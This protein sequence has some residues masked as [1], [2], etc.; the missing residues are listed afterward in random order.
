MNFVSRCLRSSVLVALAIATG[1]AQTQP[2]SPG[3]SMPQ[4]QTSPAQTPPT[5]PAETPA[6]PQAQ[7]TQPEQT[8]QSTPPAAQQSSGT[9]IAI[10]IDD[11]E[12]A[13]KQFNDLRDGVSAFVKAFGEEDELSLIGVGDKP[14]VLQDLTYDPA[15][16][17]E[18]VRKVRPQG[19]PNLASAVQ[20]AKEHLQ[21]EAEN[22][23]TAIVL[24]VGSE[25][26]I[27]VLPGAAD[28]K[29]TEAVKIPIQVI[30]SPGADWQMQEKLQELT[31]ASGGRAYF[32]PSDRQFREVAAATGKR[33]TSTKEVVSTKD[34]KSST[35][36]PRD[37]KLLAGYQE[38]TVRS[39]PVADNPETQ[40]FM[41]GD[42]LLLQRVLV[43]R[44]KRAKLFPTVIDGGT[45]RGS[46]S[47]ANA[48][49][50]TDPAAPGKKLE[51]RATLIRYDR[52]SRMRR[53]FTFGGDARLALQVDLVDPA[54]GEE[55]ESF[56]TEGSAYV[57]GVFGGSQ[58]SVLAKAMLDVANKVL[59]EL[60][61]QR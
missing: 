14:H 35:P 8:Q 46:S 51:M 26:N 28:P 33:L 39:I 20:F 22:D 17:D 3:Q 42:N 44:L 30:A 59:K 53:Q 4:T 21:S 25:P 58:E 54:T 32:P 6:T 12:P 29:T 48:M 52:G 60:Q 2:A 1:F 57:G 23:N 45:T 19:Q 49:G 15:L 50:T 41:G 61:R 10:I 40:Q 55:V 34:T 47:N 56:S 13:R 38:L 11:S 43:E 16:I 9:S 18:S 24:F 7:Q 37:R 5:V 31:A 27:N 36:W